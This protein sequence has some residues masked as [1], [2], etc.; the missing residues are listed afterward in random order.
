MR[1]K[2]KAIR[3]YSKLYEVSNTGRVRSIATG[4]MKSVF[5]DKYGY[6]IVSLYKNNGKKNCKIHRLVAVAFIP[7]KKNCPFVNHKHGDKFNNHANNLE[8][9]N[10]SHNELHKND[11]T[12]KLN[13]D[14]ESKHIKTIISRS[15]SLSAYELSRIFQVPQ[16]TIREIQGMP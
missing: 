5:T 1:E 11:Y 4:K 13:G 7:R 3:G 9:C 15:R 2:W 16:K 8:W 12:R 10:Q 14:I 6:K